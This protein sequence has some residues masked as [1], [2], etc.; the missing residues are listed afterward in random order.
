MKH[1][2]D[3]LCGKK[4]VGN[5]AN[6]KRRDHGSYS[7][8]TIGSADLNAGRLEE[9]IH[10]CPHGYVPRTPDKIFEE[11][12]HRKLCKDRRAHISL[13]YG[14][15]YTAYSREYCTADKNKSRSGL[16]LN[17]CFGKT[18]KVKLFF[19]SKGERCQAGKTLPE[20]VIDFL[21]RYRRY[22]E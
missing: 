14:L 16:A 17:Q 3:S 2:H 7:Q 21:F 5:H 20:V 18:L 4:P 15:K 6:K 10:V 8:R 22:T 12:H 19:L 11:H 1:S 13:D 9:G